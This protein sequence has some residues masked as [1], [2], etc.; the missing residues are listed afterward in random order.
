MHFIANGTNDGAAALAEAARNAPT[1]TEE[2][3]ARVRAEKQGSSEDTIRAKEGETIEQARYRHSR[4]QHLRDEQILHT[5]IEKQTQ[6]SASRSEVNQAF[7]SQTSRHYAV[8]PVEQM[9]I[10]IGGT[11][12]ISVPEARNLVLQGSLS[13]AEVIKAIEGEGRFYDPKYR[14]PKNAL[15][16]R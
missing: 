14:M 13:E 10:K 12:E 3:M 9:V 2:A 1:S 5:Q 7:Q 8:P 15:G 11:T 4:E 6:L 16:F